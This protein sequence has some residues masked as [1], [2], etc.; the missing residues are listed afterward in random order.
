VAAAIVLIAA[1][2][3]AAAPA[4]ARPSRPAILVEPHPC[5]G[6]SYPVILV[7]NDAYSP[8]TLRTS[9]AGGL[10][11][12]LD[13][14]WDG[15]TG[16]PVTASVTYRGKLALFDSGVKTSP[17]PAAY[18]R[19]FVAAGTYPYSSK[20]NTSERGS[21]QVPMCHVPHRARV[22]HEIWT[23]TSTKTLRT[24]AEDVEVKRPGAKRWTWLRTRVKDFGF[25]WKPTA[26]GTYE[27]RARLRGLSNNTTSSFSPAQSVNVS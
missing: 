18:S 6:S 17:P 4:G 11:G 24:T 20:A 2:G 1:A 9:S 16:S 21:I 19:T 5:I 10:G 22:N 23:Q 3:L 8:K 13:W 26:T 7:E 15:G 12:K 27:L 25:W 14:E